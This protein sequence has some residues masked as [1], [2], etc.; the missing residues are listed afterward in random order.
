M[1]GRFPEIV[2]AN[3]PGISNDS[4]ADLQALYEYPAELPEKLAWDY[5]TDIVFGC[6]VAYIAGNNV[7]RV[8]RYLFSIPPAFHGSDLACES[9]L[10][11]HS[12][13]LGVIVNVS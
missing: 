4:I 11:L 7:E 6:S 9:L 3:M 1:P 2:R 10:V 5:T 13:V 8:R 12:S